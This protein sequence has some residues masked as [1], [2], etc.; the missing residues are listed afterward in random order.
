V[1][2]I[3][4]RPS[5]TENTYISITGAI[6]CVECL[7]VIKKKKRY[8][9]RWISGTNKTICQ[10]KNFLI[11]KIKKIDNDINNTYTSDSDDD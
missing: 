4:C 5:N 1:R 6:V 9:K 3:L 11:D 8:G 7:H 10:M 2:V